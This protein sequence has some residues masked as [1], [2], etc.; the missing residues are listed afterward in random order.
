MTPTNQ[1]GTKSSNPIA[2]T[3]LAFGAGM[4]LGFLLIFFLLI[5]PIIRWLV[6][7]LDPL[8]LFLQLLL[9]LLLIFFSV[10]LGG[11]AAG[12]W[13]GWAISSFSEA[14]SRRKFIVHGAI[15][16]AIAHALLFIPTVALVALAAFFNQD[17]DVGL[18]K[19]PRLMGL[20]GV[21]YG[22]VGGLIFGLW[23]AGLKRALA[24]TLAS[25]AGF[26][27]GGLLL[28]L[29]IRGAAG[30][31]ARL[32]QLLLLVVAFFL[33]GAGGGAL[34]GFVYGHFHEEQI[35]FP[36][37]RFWNAVRAA[38]IVLLGFILLIAVTNIVNFLTINWP[39]LDEQ[40]ALPTEGTHWFEYD[41][42]PETVGLVAGSA[43]QVVCQDG[44]LRLSQDGQSISPE[45]WPRCFADPVVA[46]AAD[47]RAHIIYYSDQVPRNTGAIAAGHYLLES[48][49]DD[50]L[51]TEPSIVAEPAGPVEPQL[52]SGAAKELYL[53]W[54][55]EGGL[56]YAAMT[57]YSC[58]EAPSNRVSQIIL[59]AIQEGEFW[60]AGEPIAY[61]GN[62][63]DRLHF[64]P[65]PTAPEL[66]LKPT[67]N[68]AFDT[69]AKVIQNAEYEVLFVTMQWDKPSPA[70]SPGTTLT[71]TVAHI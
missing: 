70:G 68:G 55:D 5:S 22:L 39:D 59:D 47:G 25:A 51:W 11:A 14:T 16:F 52:S 43:P 37:S 17:I 66:L 63:F 49:L 27:I 15:S 42:S 26:G 36:E 48:I 71:N 9:G 6:N 65:N 64:T 44:R 1:T 35:F 45:S 41:G 34:L 19:L 18:T 13:G 29:T 58:E 28:G 54:T 53:S 61:C 7:L 30:I 2:K 23:T 10:G 67:P 46:Q 31:E 21:L 20:L 32:S 56:H 50:G 57:P 4:A 3:S 60:G 8:Q 69:V 12:A 33:F 38:G 40:L 24:V 62:R